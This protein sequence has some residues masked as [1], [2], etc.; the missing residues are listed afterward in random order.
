MS[1]DPMPRARRPWASRSATRSCIA[2]RIL[3]SF[4]ALRIL[5]S[6][7]SRPARSATQRSPSPTSVPSPVSCGPT[8]RSKK[9]PR[10]KSGQR[11]GLDWSR[12]ALSSSSSARS[13]ASN[14]GCVSWCSSSTGGATAGSAASSHAGAARPPKGSTRSR[15]PTWRSV[16]L[17]QCFVLWL[18]G[19]AAPGGRGALACRA[20][21]AGAYRGRVA[22]RRNRPRASRH[23]GRLSAAALDLRLVASGDVHMHTRAR[24]RLQDAVTSIRLGVPV[25]E[26]G[27]HL[28]PNGERY[29]REPARLAQSLPAR[30]ARGDACDRGG[31]SFL[32]RRVAL[33][34]STRAGA[35]RRDAR[36]AICAS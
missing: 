24:R 15:A 18:P 12:R 30:V 23:S 25:A 26:A 13:S 11:L 29:L 4:A 27:W 10:S 19:S 2:S 17:E 1:R 33:R 20:F 7:S 9:S 35:G 16:G 6:S 8:W 14:A 21:P 34:V 3:L 32:A 31:V 36:R 28:Y 5:R 22:L